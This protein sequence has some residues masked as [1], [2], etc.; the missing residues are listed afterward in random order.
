MKTRFFWLC[1][2]LAFA[3]TLAIVVGQRLSAEAMSV[4]VG[5]VA[6]VAASIPTSLIVVWFATRT[7]A[8][9][10][11]APSYEPQQPEARVVVVPPP[12]TT[13]V[14]HSAAAYMASG[15]STVPQF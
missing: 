13:P 9:N 3:I 4:M 6:G 8:A 12:A 5:V 10:Q 2:G 7:L 15:Y 1:L 11:P 14:L